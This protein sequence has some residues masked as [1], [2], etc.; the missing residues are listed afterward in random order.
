MV[1]KSW[2]QGETKNN[3]F[4]DQYKLNGHFWHKISFKKN[5]IEDEVNELQWNKR[6][7]ANQGVSFNI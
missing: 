2:D 7:K 5:Q 4:H 6:E 3:R 1:P